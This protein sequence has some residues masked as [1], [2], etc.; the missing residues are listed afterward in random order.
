VKNK[1]NLSPDAGRVNIKA[2]SPRVSVDGSDSAGTSR[3]SPYQKSQLRPNGKKLKYPRVLSIGGPDADITNPLSRVRLSTKPDKLNCVPAGDAKNA[4]KGIRSESSFSSKPIA[5][6][7][8]IWL[9]AHFAL[10]DLEARVLQVSGRN[11]WA[12]R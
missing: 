3:L 4:C 10:A 2:E 12:K 5:S 6:R 8:D 9:M 11:D 7:C 1:T